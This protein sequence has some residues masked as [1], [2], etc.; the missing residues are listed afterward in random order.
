M[1]RMAA[2]LSKQQESETDNWFA[3]AMY[4]VRLAEVSKRF[5]PA[6]TAY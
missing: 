6:L 2:S 5:E 3:P 1:E 4:N